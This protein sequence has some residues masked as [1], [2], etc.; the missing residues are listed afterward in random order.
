MLINFESASAA[1]TSFLPRAQIPSAPIRSD[2]GII[3][4]SLSFLESVLAIFL[5]MLHAL[6][7]S[8]ALKVDKQGKTTN[9][10]AI[11]NI[12]LKF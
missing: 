9:T 11:L 3:I 5:A 1:L 7:C 4:S 6:R 10:K 12:G 8:N 2:L